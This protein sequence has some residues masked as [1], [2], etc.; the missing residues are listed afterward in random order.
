MVQKVPVSDLAFVLLYY[1]TDEH[2]V[3]SA[4]APTLESYHHLF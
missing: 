1:R 4:L 3:A 2:D